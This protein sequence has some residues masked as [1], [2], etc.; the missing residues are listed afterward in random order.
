VNTT[1]TAPATTDTDVDLIAALEASPDFTT[2]TGKEQLAALLGITVPSA[3]TLAVLNDK[4][5][6]SGIERGIVAAGA[7]EAIVPDDVSI[8]EINVGSN[9]KVRGVFLHQDDVDQV[10]LYFF[11]KTTS[12]SVH[13]ES[14]DPD[15]ECHEFLSP[16]EMFDRIRAYYRV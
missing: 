2:V 1:T 3:D 4:A 9:A 5:L 16:E 8:E 13:I 6:A 12:V 14:E 10:A 11:D 7:I 15:E